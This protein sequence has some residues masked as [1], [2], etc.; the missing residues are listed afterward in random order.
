M[1]GT[2]LAPSPDLPHQQCRHVGRGSPVRS[3]AS[4]H[5]RPCLPAVDGAAQP[6]SQPQHDCRAPDTVA[7]PGRRRSIRSLPRTGPVGARVH[8][9]AGPSVRWG[10]S[11]PLI[12]VC[13]GSGWDDAAPIF[14]LF[15]I[16]GAL[17]TLAYVGYWVY[18][19]R[20]LT[21]RLLQYTLMSSSF[22]ITTIL[23]GSQ[24]GVLGVAGAV[25]LAPAVLWPFSLWWL[26][27]VTA[28]PL[29]PCGLVGPGCRSSL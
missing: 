25:A 26:S 20:G 13:L 4:R 16:G 8:D 24:W 3:D 21:R 22:R 29:R 14:T 7:D 23:V 28:L 19:A 10:A 6:A 17:T 11:E 5:L 18:L 12:R 2:W 9:P 27:R 1:A 15:A